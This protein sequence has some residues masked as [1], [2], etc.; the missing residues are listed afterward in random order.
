ML[1]EDMDPFL[2]A[3]ELTL[4]SIFQRKIQDVTSDASIGR[5]VTDFYDRRNSLLNQRLSAKNEVL[6]RRRRKINTEKSRGKKQKT[7]ST[8]ASPV[9][10]SNHNDTPEDDSVHNNFY[11]DLN[12]S[13]FTL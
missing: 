13:Y 8:A 6:T 5:L 12:D 2:V 4:N 11:D 3:N 9:D 7:S 1:K 10:E